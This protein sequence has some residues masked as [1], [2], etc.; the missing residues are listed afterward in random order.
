MFP[1]LW[2]FL[3]VHI[4]YPF[5]LSLFFVRHCLIHNVMHWQK[6]SIQWKENSIF[7]QKKRAQ[8]NSRKLS[9]IQAKLI[10][11][12]FDL[13]NNNIVYGEKHK[14]YSIKVVVDIKH[15]R[16]TYLTRRFKK[17]QIIA[18]ILLLTCN[19]KRQFLP[20]IFRYK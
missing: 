3:S 11:T 6:I 10:V 15:M 17:G 13:R 12:I 16:T 9:K 1:A 19:L 7:A 20:N 5:M 4:K 14:L 18:K 8:N 2:V